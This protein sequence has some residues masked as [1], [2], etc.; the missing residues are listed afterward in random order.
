MLVA[1]EGGYTLR[2]RTVHGKP[3]VD[4]DHGVDGDHAVADT[5]EKGGGGG[6]IIHVGE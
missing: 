5:W 6:G 1:G 4:T 3:I 2:E